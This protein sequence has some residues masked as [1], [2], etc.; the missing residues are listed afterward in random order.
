MK[1]C[2]RTSTTI[3]L[4]VNWGKTGLWRTG[5]GVSSN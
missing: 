3:W 4:G 2:S 5:S 1:L